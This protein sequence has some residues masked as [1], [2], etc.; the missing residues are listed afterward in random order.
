MRPPKSPAAIPDRERLV[1]EAAQPQLGGTA[2]LWRQW[3]AVAQQHV[4]ALLWQSQVA[5]R[6]RPEAVTPAARVSR[7]GEACQV[8][9]AAGAL[10]QQTKL[11]FEPLMVQESELMCGGRGK[12]QQA[13]CTSTRPGRRQTLPASR[14]H[15]L[16]VHA[17]TLLKATQCV[18]GV[19]CVRHHLCTPAAVSSGT[20]PLADPA[21]RDQGVGQCTNYR[22]RGCLVTA[23]LGLKAVPRQVLTAAIHVLAANVHAENARRRRAAA[24]MSLRH[25]FQRHMCRAVASKHLHTG[26]PAGL[27]GQDEL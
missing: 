8:W 5:C 11:P 23:M 20:R 12:H 16:L 22:W 26:P 2:A 24:A 3:D 18:R 4:T 7:H 1:R 14:G 27:Q 17:A 9:V 10:R 6:G 21:Q 25:P 15:H 19:Q 13:D